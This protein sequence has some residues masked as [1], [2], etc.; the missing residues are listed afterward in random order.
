MKYII[1]Y[2]LLSFFLNGY[3]QHYY[4][5]DGFGMLTLS[6]KGEFKLNLF[7]S[8]PDSGIYKITGDTLV[9]NS[10]LNPIEFI[11]INSDSIIQLSGFEIPFRVYDEQCMVLDTLS[12]FDTIN[13]RV[14][15]DV[16]LRKGSLLSFQFLG[17]F[18]RGILKEELLGRYWVNL[19]FSLNRKVYFSDYQLLMLKGVLV[20]FRELDNDVFDKINGFDFMPMKSG[21]K[22]GD[23]KTY[24][25]GMGGSN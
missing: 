18:Y 20:P 7:D 22:G 14:F 11:N 5:V 13:E 8:G 23:Y 6:K 21:K 16:D 25:S 3:S 17:M 12:Y 24:L 9:L 1:S 2:C 15:I 10:L 19:D 4:G